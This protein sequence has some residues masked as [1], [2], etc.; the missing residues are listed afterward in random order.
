MAVDSTRDD[1]NLF[2]IFEST[3]CENRMTS[4]GVKMPSPYMTIEFS[5]DTHTT[6]NSINRISRH[7]ILTFGEFDF[8]RNKSPVMNLPDVNS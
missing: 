3:S 7:R 2:E 4:A 6:S 1:G 5:S 8:D